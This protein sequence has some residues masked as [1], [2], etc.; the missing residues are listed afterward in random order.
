M[1]NSIE[2]VLDKYWDRLLPVDPFKIA[3]RWGARIEPIENNEAVNNNEYS[4]GAVITNGVYYI[5]YNPNE[6]RNRQ[7]F[8]IAHEL[9]HH[10]LGHT[11]DGKHHFDGAQN[12]FSNVSSMPE[13]QA[14]KFAIAL[15]MPRQAIMYYITR[16]G[17]DTT[18]ELAK[19]FNMSEDVMR[20]RL[21][22]MGIFN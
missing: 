3:A 16:G 4:G 8:T 9:A 20:L 12:Y 13:K 7:R 14:N 1:N 5:Y 6:H 15:L 19:I 17:V 22:E 18:L 2:D 21:K 10:V 11:K